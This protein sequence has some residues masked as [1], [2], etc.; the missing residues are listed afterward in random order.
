MENNK[1]IPKIRFEGFTDACVGWEKS[2]ILRLVQVIYKIQMTMVNIHFL[3]VL[4]IL[5]E[6][7]AISLREKQF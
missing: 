7:I 3:F 5:S 1:T 4:K 2:L 6:V